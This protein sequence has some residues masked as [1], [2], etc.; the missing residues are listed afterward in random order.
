M[1][2]SCNNNR[3]TDG[4][5]IGRPHGPQLRDKCHS[6]AITTERLTW[7]RQA[8]RAAA[9]RQ[10]SQSCNNNRASDRHCIGRPHGPQL[11]DKCHSLA[12]TTERLTWYRQ[13]TRA[14]AQRQVSQSCNNNRASDRHCI[15]RPHGPQLRDKCH[16]LAITTERLT[17]YRQAT[18]AAAQRQVSQSCNNNRATDGHCIGR[19]HG[20]QLGDKCHSLAITTER[21][22][23]I[24]SAGHTG[25]SSETSVSVL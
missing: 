9:Q 11:R 14:A 13:A 3:A 4:H 12:I 22:T 21:P 15:G 19:P 2:Q 1:S 6:L 10:V 17:W 20:P 23:D 25:R 5:C 18:R 8:T 24:V 7:Y 16:S